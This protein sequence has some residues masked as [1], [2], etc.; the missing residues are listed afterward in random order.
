MHH[1]SPVAPRKQGGG[2]PMHVRRQ[3]RTALAEGQRELCCH[4]KP[5]S[6]GYEDHEPV[7][8]LNHMDMVCVADEGFS[9]NP[10]KDGITPETIEIDGEKWMRAKG[11][12]LGA[13]NGMGLAMALSIL[14][15]DSLKH[16]ALEVLTTTN[17]ED[18]MSGAASLAQDFIRGRRVLNLASEAYDE[19]TVGAAGRSYRPHTFR[20]RKYRNL[21]V[22]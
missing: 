21:T 9:F 7:V 17:E 20:S 18:G 22:M 19:I 14:A 3:P 15:D 8:I 2:L 16:P 13:D 1:P 6:P 11:T 12:S 10:L 5:A 4:R